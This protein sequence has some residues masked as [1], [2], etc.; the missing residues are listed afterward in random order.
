M[1]PKE[2]AKELFDTYFQVSG[3]KKGYDDA[4][5]VGT[6]R[7]YEAIEYAILSVSDTIIACQDIDYD[8]H[9]NEDAPLTSLF[10]YHIEYW[11]D[12]KKELQNLK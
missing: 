4:T 10:N 7:Y 1:T 12:V 8:W 5:W 2:K 11:K 9:K 3:G 6:E